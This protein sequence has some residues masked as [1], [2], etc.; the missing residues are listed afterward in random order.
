MKTISTKTMMNSGHL[1]KSSG[2]FIKNK[3]G[4]PKKKIKHFR[5]II[6]YEYCGCT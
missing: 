4:K 5:R 6:I 2:E 3:D 1:P